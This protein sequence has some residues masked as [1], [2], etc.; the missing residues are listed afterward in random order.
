MIVG[1]V[2]VFPQESTTKTHTVTSFIVLTLQPLFRDV[3]AAGI[4]QTPGKRVH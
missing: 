2:V 4:F 1:G 3:R